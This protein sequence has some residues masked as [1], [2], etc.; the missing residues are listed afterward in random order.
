MEKLT[1]HQSAFNY[2][3][4]AT[5]QEPSEPGLPA[6]RRVPSVARVAQRRPSTERPD[7]CSIDENLRALGRLEKSMTGNQNVVLLSVVAGSKEV[8]QEEEAVRERYPAGPIGSTNVVR[9]GWEKDSPFGLVEPCIAP[10][11]LPLSTDQLSRMY[12]ARESEDDE[13]PALC[14]IP[15]G[16]KLAVFKSITPIQF[17]WH[18]HCMDKPLN[19]PWEEDNSSDDLCDVR[20]SKKRYT[21]GSPEAKPRNVNKNEGVPLRKSMPSCSSHGMLPRTALP[22]GSEEKRLSGPTRILKSTMTQ[23]GFEGCPLCAG[24]ARAALGRTQGPFLAR[25]P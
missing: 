8:V 12:I 17:T 25:Q 15:Y 13:W 4:P 11:E 14:G 16:R 10:P 21:A 2:I 24:A 19:L 23:R 6:E 20:F 5:R 22:E 3:L 1:Q 7:V 9:D 18:V